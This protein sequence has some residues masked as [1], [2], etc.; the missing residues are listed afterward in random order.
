M[1]KKPTTP[2]K[3]LTRPRGS[4]VSKCSLKLKY[5]TMEKVSIS[6]ENVF[7]L[8]KRKDCNGS[9]TLAEMCS[10]YLGV[11]LINSSKLSDRVCKACGRRIRN[12]S[13]LL[14]VIK[15]ACSQTHICKQ[16]IIKRDINRG[17]STRF[18]DWCRGVH[19]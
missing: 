16:A 9:Q 3:V 18:R 11:E 10:V 6:T 2:T 7:K 19:L 5:G 1:S 4:K 8:S 12:T 14:S 15:L 13:E 17:G